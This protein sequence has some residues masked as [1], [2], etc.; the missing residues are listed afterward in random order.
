M[1]QQ[2]LNSFSCSGE[3]KIVKFGIEIRSTSPEQ[4]S[5]E[6]VLKRAARGGDEKYEE[7]Y[8]YE[9]SDMSD[10]NSFERVNVVS[11]P[12]Y[13]PKRDELYLMLAREF[14][15]K[16]LVPKLDPDLSN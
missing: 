5:W 3:P 11:D 16:R 15:R 9:N 8:S 13:A 7:L 6:N 1:R 10:F 4:N 12:D 14:D 2:D